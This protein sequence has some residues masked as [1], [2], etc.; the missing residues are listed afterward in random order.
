VIAG[1]GTAILELIEDMAAEGLAPDHLAICTGG[2][3]LLAGSALAA[4][5]WR[6]G[7]SCMRSS[8][9]AGTITAARCAPA[10]LSPM[11]ARAMAFAT[12]CCPP[13]GRAHLRRQPRARGGGVSVSRAE[14]FAAMRFAFTHLKLVVEP[15][16]AVALAAVLAGK[17]PTPGAV[18]GIILSGGNVDPA[19]FAE[20]MAA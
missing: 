5:R 7:P 15:G 10:I 4:R 1:Q 14:V 8:R 12:R 19:R 16:G 2:G 18:S 9:R 11:T 20:A 3:G 13:A 6:R 17:L